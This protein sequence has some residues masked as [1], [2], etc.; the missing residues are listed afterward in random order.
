MISISASSNHL[1][2]GA[3]QPL[4]IRGWVVTV[5]DDER[6][7][8][9]ISGIPDRISTTDPLTATF[10]FNGDVT[11]FVSND[12]TVTGATKGAFTAKSATTYTLALTPHGNTDVVV[13]TAANSATYGL[14]NTG[15]ANT[16][17]KTAVW[18]ATPSSVKIGNASATEGAAMTFSITLSQSVSGGLTVT[19]SFTDGTAGK[20]VDYTVNTSP[21][22]FAGTSGEIQMFTVETIED[23]LVEEDEIFTVGLTISGTTESVIAI[24]TGT[25][26]IINDDTPSLQTVTL[27]VTPNPVE[28]GESITVQAEMSGIMRETMKIPIMLEPGTAEPEDHT[29][30]TEILIKAGLTSGNGVITTFEDTD[31][32]DETFTIK[33]GT[34]PEGLEK[35]TPASVEVTIL[36]RTVLN[37]PPTVLLSCTPCTVT[38]GDQVNLTATATDPDGDPLTYAWGAT[39]GR[40]KE[41][42]DAPTIIWTAPD[43][44]GEFTI[45][46]EV[47]DGAGGI[48]FAEVELEVFN[49]EPAFAQPE[50]RFKFPE[51]REGPIHLGMVT[52]AD[53]DDHD[54]EYQMVLGDS[55]RFSVGI[56][57]GRIH[58]IGSGEDYEIEPNQFDLTVRVQDEFGGKDSVEVLVRVTDVNEL[59]T[60]TAM[61][62]PCTVA[63][64]DRVQLTASATDPDDDQLKYTWYTEAGKFT[65]IDEPIVHWIAP[66][67]TGRVEIRVEVSDGR[68]GSA[69]AS[70]TVKVFNRPPIFEVSTYTFELPE[71]VNGQMKQAYLGTVHAIDPDQDALTYEILGGDQQRFKVGKQ[72]GR[73]QYIGAG[74]SFETLPNQFELRIRSQDKFQTGAQTEVVISVTNVNEAPEAVHDEVVTMEDQP[75]TIDVL[76]NDTDPENDRLRVQSVT[77]AMHGAVDIDSGGQVR[78]TPGMNY[79][80]IDQFDYVISDEQG[81]TDHASVKVNILS[82]NDGPTAVG[83]IPVQALDEGGEELRLD[84]SP[85]FVDVD[86]DPLT[87]S[88]QISNPGVVLAEVVQALLVLTPVGYG[89]VTVTVMAADPEG[90]HA[91]QQ[92][93][94]GVSDRPQRAIIE[95]LLA[96]TARNHLASLRIALS[97][98]MEVGSCEESRLEVMGRTLPLSRAEL[99]AVPREIMR[100][101]VLSMTNSLRL[102]SKSRNVEQFSGV[103]RSRYRSLPFSDSVPLHALDVRHGFSTTT[104]EFLLG[105]GGSERCSGRWSLWGRGD[106]QEFKGVP[107]VY[108]YNAGYDGTLASAYVGLDTQLGRRWLAGVALS[109]SRSTGD[110][111]AAASGGRVTQQMTGIYPYLRWAGRSTSIWASVG[112]GS[113]DAKNLRN[114]GR[115]GT[116]SE[117][118]RIWLVELERRFKRGSRLGFA[119]RGDAGSARLRTSKGKETIDDQSVIVN[120]VRIGVDLSVPM[121]LSRVEL[122]PFGTVHARHDGGAGQTGNGIEVTG[123]FQMAI[124][125]VR[126]DARARTL[127]Y[128]SVEGYGE[129]GAAI[130]LTLGK[131]R[132]HKGFTF[133][134]SP[135]WG[136]PARSSDKLFQD[137]GLLGQRYDESNQWTLSAQANYTVPLPIGFRLDLR[138]DYGGQFGGPGFGVRITHSITHM[139]HQYGAHQNGE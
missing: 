124:G 80:G 122:N 14:N 108:G 53:S 41:P 43:E 49:H 71:N 105:W 136:S 86:G 94:V 51:N 75:V 42:L 137:R 81:L 112:A 22:S 118:L 57:D 96:A 77:D 2:P 138:G 119:L 1:P 32:D 39:M 70:V 107:S 34:M 109:Q 135:R 52:A 47:S 95:H 4:P 87:Y 50:Y 15:P 62:D 6:L 89:T 69:A 30:M 117:N 100:T 16:V 103:P 134:I 67:D 7:S 123:G 36:D 111:Y 17:S 54:L 113:G 66:S 101:T 110:W 13:T 38:P 120:Q 128:H 85:Y 35:G 23:A 63:R 26:T 76:A 72:D 12:V 56:S 27:S 114:T 132:N 61:C 5:T 60:V 59:P 92:I 44:S 10:T 9:D 46:V 73:V 82:V 40:F 104:A 55:D 21:I 19:P 116:S 130:T 106:L 65:A 20:G 131:K 84:L 37:Q 33:L 127:A 91:T 25:G 24:D 90:L 139:S 31:Q 93:Q 98:R 83:T 28:E 102:D 18:Y 29:P 126:L 78:Y 11:D 3:N 58:Y 115:R 125:I 79:H 97:Q 133:L 88:T 129:R 8:L 99:V 68:E 74:E 64:G 48:S 45:R 121:R